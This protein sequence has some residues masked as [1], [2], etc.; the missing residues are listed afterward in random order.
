VLKGVDRAWEAGAD[1][2]NLS[3]VGPDNPL[4]AR[5]MD[6]LEEL[7]AVV[8]AAAGNEASSE[9]RYP[10]AYASV[11]GVGAIDSDGK[12]YARSN[13]GPSSELLAPGVEVLSTAP[14]DAFSFGSGTSFSAAHVT[15]AL[16][17]LIGSGFSPGTARM[18]LF[19]EASSRKSLGGIPILPPVCDVLARL[20]RPC[21]PAP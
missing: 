7:G 17:I 10:A 13:R 6:R 20:Q 1:V 2:I 3:I 8:V 12:L 5:S 14:G 9:P 18:A 16:A 11:I 21:P 19:Q 4:L 15:G